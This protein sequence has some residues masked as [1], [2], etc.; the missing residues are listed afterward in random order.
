MDKGLATYEYA[1]STHY[2][3]GNCLISLFRPDQDRYI[4]LYD[5]QGNLL[6]ETNM[7]KRKDYWNLFQI[8]LRW[9]SICWSWVEFG[10]R[11]L[12]RLRRFIGC[13]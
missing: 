11:R 4:M 12:S 10:R 2:V 1:L 7:G 3:Y 13:D 6:W 8:K 9:K 5:S